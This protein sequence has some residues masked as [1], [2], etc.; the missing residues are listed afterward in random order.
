M[1]VG[2]EH[3][4]Q[5]VRRPRSGLLPTTHL[6]RWAVGLAAAFFPLVFAAAV[7]PRGAALGFACGIAGGAAALLAIIRDG[8]RAVIVLAAV[9]PV[10]IAVGFVLAELI[11]GAL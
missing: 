8:E 6:G 11:N 5:P 2:A 3:P 7:V 10:V 9:A 1:R 4:R